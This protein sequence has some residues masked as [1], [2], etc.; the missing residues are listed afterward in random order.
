MIIS[1]I[2]SL[3]IAFLIYKCFEKYGFK[4][5]FFVALGL[6]LVS[7]LIQN[8]TDHIIGNIILT[9]LISLINTAIDYWIFQK[10][11]SFWS[12]IAL[13]VLLGIGFILIMSFVIAALMGGSGLL[14]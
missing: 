4:Q 7:M 10:T 8:G 5:G 3:L 13:S 11:N 14:P 6:N 12:Y 1:L 2:V 9:A